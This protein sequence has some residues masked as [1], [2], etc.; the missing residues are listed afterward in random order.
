MRISGQFFGPVYHKSQRRYTGWPAGTASLNLGGQHG[1]IPCRG[2]LAS[3]AGRPGWP[4]KLASQAGKLV[5]PAKGASLAGKPGWPAKLT[6][7]AGQPGL[8]WPS[9]IG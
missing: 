4:D 2:W 6:S 7:Q 3:R 1:C 9:G 8:G 5:W